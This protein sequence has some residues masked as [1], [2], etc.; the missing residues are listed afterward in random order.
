MQYVVTE[1]GCVNLQFSSVPDRVKKLISIAHPDYRDE[2][3]Y[4]AR[5]A[6]LL[7]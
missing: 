2:L 6:G 3:M 7:Y 5:T 1:Y 4:Q